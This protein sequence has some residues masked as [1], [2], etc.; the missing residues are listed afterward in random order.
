VE[1]VDVMVIERYPVVSGVI[2]T[3]DWLVC[4]TAGVFALVVTMAVTLTSPLR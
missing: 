3:D 2:E 4:I 1:L